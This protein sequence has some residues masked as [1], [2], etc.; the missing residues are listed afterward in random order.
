M[1]PKHRDSLIPL[2]V[3]V[4]L[5]FC[6]CRGLPFGPE[7]DGDSV[8]APEFGL[9]TVPRQWE[10]AM[11]D[12]DTSARSAASS[13]SLDENPD[14]DS[15]DDEAAPGTRGGRKSNSRKGEAEPE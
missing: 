10:P 14:G 1:L 11:E 9:N 12:G 7:S 13:A 8:A 3:A 5:A 4:C 2:L 15:G 6:G